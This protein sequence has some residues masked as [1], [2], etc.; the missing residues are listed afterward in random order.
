M[1]LRFIFVIFLLSS[2]IAYAQIS[3]KKVSSFVKEGNLDAL[4]TLIESGQDINAV[5]R[6]NTLLFL[7]AEY[8]KL[9]IVKYLVDKGANLNVPDKLGLTPLEISI[10]NFWNGDSIP[11]YL[12]T[13][14][15]DPNII[16]IHGANALRSSIGF[17]KGSG[18]NPELFKFLIDH[19]A[20]I[21]YNCDKCCN[22]TAFLRSCIFG[23][24]EMLEYLI[25][26]KVNI[27]QTD[28]KGRNG[29]MC[30][31][32][33]KNKEVIRFL[34]NKKDIDI[35]HKDKKQKTVLD[36]ALKSNDEEIINLVK[37]AVLKSSIIN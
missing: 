16:G 8:G 9:N 34:L 28:C 1:L 6:G 22:Q 19:G 4:K 29:L 35:N 18:C 12:I 33:K 5:Y 23:D 20:D 17:G 24:A 7:A 21:N 3:Y 32:I 27:N 31:I 25:E 11:Y 30:A 13:K 14:G 10:S 36:Y 26:R 2:T 15:A 37:S